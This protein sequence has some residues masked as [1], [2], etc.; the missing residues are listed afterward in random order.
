MKFIPHKGSAS[1]IHRPI[2]SVQC[3]HV[4]ENKNT[5]NKKNYKQ[6]KKWQLKTQHTID[7][8]ISAIRRFYICI[9]ETINNIVLDVIWSRLTNNHII[10]TRQESKLL[11]PQNRKKSLKRWYYPASRWHSGDVK[12]HPYTI[13][14]L[15]IF[16]VLDPSPLTQW[17]NCSF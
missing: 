14:F 12:N 3:V 15:M 4:L 5:G 13:T 6:I 1:T 2:H 8:L 17:I 10:M 9:N 11:R 16:A 7:Q